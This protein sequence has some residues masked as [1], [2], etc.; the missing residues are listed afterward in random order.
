M[1][2]FH[3][4]MKITRNTCINLAKLGGMSGMGGRERNRVNC[5]TGEGRFL[6]RALILEGEVY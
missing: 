6:Q 4:I 1:E 2:G 5:V 3:S